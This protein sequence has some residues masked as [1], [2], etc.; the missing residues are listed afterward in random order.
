MT[1]PPAGEDVP[2]DKMGYELFLA[3][4]QP[5]C[6]I[7]R[8]TAQ[9]VTRHLETTSYESATDVETRAVLRATQ[10]WCADHAGQWLEQRDA[11]GTALIYKD[12]LD[13]VRR[14]LV[15]A[16][17]L[18]AGEAE[19]E[20]LLTRLRGRASRRGGLRPGSRIA[21]ALEPQGTCPACTVARETERVTVGTF[22]GA[23]ASAA[24]LAAYRQHPTGIC[25]PHLRAVL[26]T[27][28]DPALVAAL[29][30]AHAALL[31]RISADLAEV[32]RKHDYRFRDEERGAEFEAVAQA[33][34]HTAGSLPNLSGAG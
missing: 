25:L 23:L 18:P 17:G 5:G 28:P 19:P 30:E 16:A 15:G 34:A 6:P 8:R 32:I 11:L 2:R 24:F 9:A 22:A 27:T 26:A 1:P 20:A 21:A 7:C 4:R 3:L 12:V 13:N 29:V 10:G 33:V 31:G 14:A